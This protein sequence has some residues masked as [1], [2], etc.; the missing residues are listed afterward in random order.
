MLPASLLLSAVYF[1]TIPWHPFPASL[2]VKA[3]AMA[4]LSIRAARGRAYVLA[5]GLAFSA[6][7][8][9]LLEYSPGLFVAGLVAFLAAHIAYT[10]TFV[11]AWRSARI[12]VAAV[13]VVLYS[14]SLAAWLI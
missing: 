12:S 14:A 2:I 7:G 9:A 4:I 1:L 5:L 6:L 10:V 11:R 8:D 3:A 13:T